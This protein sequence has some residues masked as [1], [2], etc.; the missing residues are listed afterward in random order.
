MAKFG[1]NKNTRESA[2]NQAKN[3]LKQI[4]EKHIGTDRNNFDSLVKLAEYAN[5]HLNCSLKDVTQE[6]ALQYLSDR[7]V[8]HSQSSLNKDTLAFQ[9]MFQGAKV[10]D[11]LSKNE[12]LPKIQSEI[13]QNNASRCYTQRQIEIV[14]Q[15]QTDKFAL[16]TQIAASAGLRA[17]ELLTLQR[18]DER[19]PSERDKCL[20]AKNLK[21]KGLD[22]EKYTV[23]GKGGLIREIVIPTHLAEKLEQH[24]LDQPT[25][26]TDR[27]VHYLSKYD[28]PGGQRWS[29][30]FTKAAER[31]LGWTTGAH[32]LRHTYAQER[33]S[34]LQNTETYQT[35]LAVISQELGH[36][37][38]D[39]TLVYLR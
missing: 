25:Q 16:S 12:R 6:Q 32:G 21:F 18:I 4:S 7:S 34:D 37:R 13:E 36:F 11:P 30:S 35:A 20:E 14:Q 19:S 5:S 8:D 39:I 33:M 2:E 15:H 22:G 3:I 17:H 24:R 10:A 29:N 1:A 28:I 31:A 38:P 9:R 27:E 26:I 23:Q